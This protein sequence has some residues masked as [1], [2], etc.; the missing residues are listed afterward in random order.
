[1]INQT[2]TSTNFALD[3]KGIGDLRLKAKLDNTEGIRIAAQQFEAL[4]MNMMLKSMREAVPKSGL[5]DSNQTD[6][7]TGIL[8]QQTSQKLA[9]SHGIGLADML[10][11]QLTRAAGLVDP[12]NPA[13]SPQPAL[14]R[15]ERTS[16]NNAA[17]PEK[18]Y[19]AA[20][21]ESNNSATP[22][23][24]SGAS[25]LKQSAPH[26]DFVDR[27]WPH[28]VDASQALGVPPHFLIGQAALESGWGQREIRGADGKPSYNIFGVKAGAEW[29]GEVAEA[30]TTEYVNGA[31]QK[32][33]ERFRAYASYGEAFRDYIGVLRNNPRY[34]Q[35]A[36]GTT[37]VAKFAQ[38]LQQAGYATDPLY[39]NKLERIVNGNT[40]R[41]AL[42]A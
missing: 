26:K 35:I 37:D 8:D 10:V 16:Q 4:F 31:P 41:Q 23:P 30:Q 34:A 3:V 29:H 25:A 20:A 19:I 7:F 40:L 38:G 1:M 28:A 21:S 6:L 18:Q 5:F 27:V 2:D 13:L 14:P 22:V 36:G 9:A 15:V 32:S 11:K 42:L 33:V 17:V 12:A 24:E 39:A